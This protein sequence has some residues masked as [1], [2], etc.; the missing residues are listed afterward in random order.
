MRVAAPMESCL[1][2]SLFVLAACLAFIDAVR[3]SYPS[4]S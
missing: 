1:G 3:D 4:A 2:R